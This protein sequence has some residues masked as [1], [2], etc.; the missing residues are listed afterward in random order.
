MY[1]RT[2]Y[3]NTPKLTLD[4]GT[5]LETAKENTNYKKPIN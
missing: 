2:R 3:K 4:H 5:R 1:P